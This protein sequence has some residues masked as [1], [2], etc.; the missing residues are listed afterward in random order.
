MNRWMDFIFALSGLVV[1]SPLFLILTIWIKL[2]SYGPVF[3]RGERS[4]QNHSIFQIL[5]FRTMVCDACQ[6]GPPI[7]TCNDTR[8]TRSGRFL[9]KT[10]LDE[11]PQLINVLK[12]EMSFVGPRPEDPDIVRQYN[13]DQKDIL[14]YKPGITSPAS[15]LFRDE[16]IM[17]PAA[18]W[19]SV[20][21]KQ[22]LPKKIEMDL[23]YM[24]SASLWSDMKIILMTLGIFGQKK[25]NI[26]HKGEG[27]SI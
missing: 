9:R 4:G 11:L 1:I 20:Y 5:K 25:Q 19:E 12:G 24:K 27:L 7:T 10:K 26:H 23:E 13:H 3:F 17:I 16:E 8:I 14:K 21:I 22:I 18:L 2:D 6:S 15:H